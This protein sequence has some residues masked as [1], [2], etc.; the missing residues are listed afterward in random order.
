[1]IGSSD[2]GDWEVPESTVSQ[3][4]THGVIPVR[5]WRPKNQESKWYRFQC[6]ASRPETQ[7]EPRFQFKFKGKKNWYPSSIIRQE[8]V[9][10]I[11]EVSPFVLFRPPTVWM[12]SMHIRESNQ[13][14]SLL[15][16]MLIWKHPHRCRVSRITFGLISRHSGPVTL[17]HKMYHNN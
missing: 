13:L 11:Q 12:R 6:E 9:L 15:I 16:Q 5:V 8:E 4:E 1:M 7:G 14:Y 2:Y 3:L 17:T 10:S